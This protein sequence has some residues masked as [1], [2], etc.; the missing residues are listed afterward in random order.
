LIESEIVGLATGKST[1]EC[2]SKL[3]S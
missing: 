2:A 1:Q 3:P